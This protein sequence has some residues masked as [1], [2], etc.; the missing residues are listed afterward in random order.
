MNDLV[1]ELTKLKDSSSEPWKEAVLAL[2]A[3]GMEKHGLEGF[4]KVS[5]LL[6]SLMNNKTTSLEWVDLKTASDILAHLQNAEAD[7]K[8]AVNAFLSQLGMILGKIAGGALKG[9]L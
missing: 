9:L 5:L 3:Q 2:V 7:K 4:Q 6:A 8:L 1:H